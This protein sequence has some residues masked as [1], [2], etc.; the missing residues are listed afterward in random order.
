[1]SFRKQY[2]PPQRGVFRPGVLGNDKMSKLAVGWFVL[3][4]DTISYRPTL[5]PGMVEFSVGLKAVIGVVKGGVAGF[6]H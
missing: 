3:Q 2:H 5:S 4:I 6:S 1:M